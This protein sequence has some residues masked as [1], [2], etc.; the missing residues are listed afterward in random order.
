MTRR[1]AARLARPGRS[2]DPA[3]GAVALTFD[4]GPDPDFTP[5]VLDV[6][7]DCQAPATFFLVGRRA[8][9]HPALVRRMVAAGH[10]VGSHSHSH[11]EPWAVGIGELTREY[12]RGDAEVA[13]A[14]GCPVPMFRP[15][16]GYIDLRGAAVMR[17]LRLRPWLWTRD[18]EDW[19][20]GITAA[21]L[22]AAAH[23]ARAGEVLLMHDGMEAAP[24]PQA[25]D[26][27]ATVAALPN[28]IEDL[29]SRGLRLVRLPS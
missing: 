6:L 18:L 1:A 16:K 28:I 19:R 23:L 10:A 11:P 14:A 24:D 26:R 8:V 27:S 17:A 3:A 2:L 21:D 12:R 13:A 29:R 25:V 5:E 4:D 7:E 22:T 15:P 9:E 20:P